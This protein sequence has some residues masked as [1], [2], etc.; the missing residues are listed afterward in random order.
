MSALRLGRGGSIIR[1]SPHHRRR[2]IDGGGHTV[3]VYESVIVRVEAAR[4][5][6]THTEEGHNFF[7]FNILITHTV[8]TRNHDEPPG[9]PGGLKDTRSSRM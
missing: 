7:F 5:G 8:P 4:G 3:R 6:R 1:H 2:E 9:N